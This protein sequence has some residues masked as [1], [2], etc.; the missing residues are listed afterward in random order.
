MEFRVLEVLM[1]GGV[2]SSRYQAGL[3]FLLAIVILSRDE[4]KL[5]K[6]ALVD[7]EK[8]I[9]WFRSN[10]FQ[11]EAITLENIVNGHHKATTT[12]A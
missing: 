1:F 10:G 6:N 3:I 9:G 2:R 7:L 8:T 5:A 11:R 12:S 4:M